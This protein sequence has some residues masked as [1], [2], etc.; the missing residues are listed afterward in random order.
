MLPPAGGVPC[1]GCP[2]LSRCCGFENLLWLARSSSS[3]F[4]GAPPPNGL[5]AAQKVVVLRLACDR[6]CQ[7]T[8]TL[9]SEPLHTVRVHSGGHALCP[10]LPPRAFRSAAKRCLYV[11][12]WCD[13]P[14]GGGRTPSPRNWPRPESQ[15]RPGGGEVGASTAVVLSPVPHPAASPVGP[16]PGGKASSPTLRLSDGA[17]TRRLRGRSTPEN[18]LVVNMRVQC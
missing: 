15:P 17:G 12:S 11:N 4:A 1:A 18:T 9:A 6:T 7:T 8:H 2:L 16:G 14:P 3:S 13:A 5:L 10:P